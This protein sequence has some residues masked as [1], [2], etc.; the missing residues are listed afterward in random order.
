MKTALKNDKNKSQTIK[1][2]VRYV[3]INYLKNSRDELV[4]MLTEND[5]IM[6]KYKKNKTSFD[7][8]APDVIRLFFAHFVLSFSIDSKSLPWL[9]S[10]ISFYPI[11]IS[12]I[13]LFLM[14]MQP[15]S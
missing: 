1:S 2:P 7:E 8:Y 6:V 15:N 12:R 14:M 4:Q 10:Q 11:I 3:R 13:F 9:W 5:F